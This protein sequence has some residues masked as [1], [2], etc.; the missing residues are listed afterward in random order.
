MPLFR[1]R[2]HRRLER[3]EHLAIAL[4]KETVE[5]VV[6]LAR[7]SG[8][9]GVSIAYFVV[10]GIAGLISATTIFLMKRSQWARLDT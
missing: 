3:N 10:L 9:L 7:A 1:A 6:I 5:L 4:R 8:A 2:F